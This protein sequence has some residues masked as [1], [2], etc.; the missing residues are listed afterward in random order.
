MEIS[1][2]KL[3]KARIDGIKTTLA[4]TPPAQKAHHAG[5]AL[6]ENFNDSVRAIA[7]AYPSLAEA[8]PKPLATNGVFAD[9]GKSSV[10]LV[11]LEA[12][13]EQTL[14]LLRL[15]DQV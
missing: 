15:V 12:F 5:L 11:D 14:N 7:D 9:M 4:T 1:K 10:T 13:C 8:L 2:A 3:L 6:V